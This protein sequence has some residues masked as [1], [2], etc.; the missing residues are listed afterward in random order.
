MPNRPIIEDTEDGF[1][2]GFA[3][4][5]IALVIVARMMGAW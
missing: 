2:W 3:A 5:L 1:V 4:A